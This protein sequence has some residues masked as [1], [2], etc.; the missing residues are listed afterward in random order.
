MKTW[1]II[2]LPN[3]SSTK[4][5]LA[6]IRSKFLACV[7]ELYI[8]FVLL[9]YISK[10][11]HVF[12]VASVLFPFKTLKWW[13]ILKNLI[14]G[15]DNYLYNTFVWKDILSSLLMNTDRWKHLHQQR[16][17]HESFNRTIFR[18]WDR[19]WIDFYRLYSN[20]WRNE[21][22]SVHRISYRK[23]SIA[24]VLTL[25]KQAVYWLLFLLV[26]EMNDYCHLIVAIN[27]KHLF[28]C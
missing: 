20:M 15:C 14:F 11:G 25:F 17:V 24:F 18:K 3:L 5:H 26:G 2:L 22:K 7:Y 27:F 9:A 6:I 21:R 23:K 16:E 12:S 4:K 8:A 1:K 10:D 13:K 19:F 28:F